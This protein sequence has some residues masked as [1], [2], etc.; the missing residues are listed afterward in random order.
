VEEAEA[1]RCRLHFDLIIADIPQKN[2]QEE[3]TKEKVQ[4]KQYKR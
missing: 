3:K 2:R 1:L 4:K